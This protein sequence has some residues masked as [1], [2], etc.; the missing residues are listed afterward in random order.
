[1]IVESG[2][3]VRGK[4]AP[5]R[6]MSKSKT[7]TVHKRKMDSKWIKGT[8]VG[9]VDRSHESI[10][11]TPQ[12]KAV[13]VRTIKRIPLEERWDLKAIEEIV[14]TPRRPVPGQ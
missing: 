11:V 5:R 10:L 9:M 2:E 1:M 6:A 13:R 4:L 8:W 14:A 3:Q 12:G 7:K